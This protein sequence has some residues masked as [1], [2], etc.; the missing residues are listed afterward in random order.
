MLRTKRL[1][2]VPPWSAKHLSSATSSAD[3]HFRSFRRARLYRC[4]Y[5]C[6]AF[7]TNWAI[8]AFL[9]SVNYRFC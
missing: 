1:M 4:L 5:R 6:R 7:V 8:V 2:A 9:E 3:Q